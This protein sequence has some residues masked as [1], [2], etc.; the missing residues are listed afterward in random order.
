MYLC[1][2]AVDQFK[3]DVGVALA[4]AVDDRRQPVRRYARERSDP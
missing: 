2:I 3:S 4:K 1:V